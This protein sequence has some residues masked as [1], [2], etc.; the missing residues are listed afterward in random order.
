MNDRDSEER[1]QKNWQNQTDPTSSTNWKHI[2]DEQMNK[3]RRKISVEK[4]RTKRTIENLRE[5][6]AE[7][8]M[9]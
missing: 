9:N 2:T 6:L 8:R 4:Q 1:R 5:K 7:S 3:R